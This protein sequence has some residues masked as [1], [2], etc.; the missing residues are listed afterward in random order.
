MLTKCNQSFPFGQNFPK[1]IGHG[2]SSRVSCFK[3]QQDPAF[4]DQSSNGL[5]LG[6]TVEMFLISLC[7]PLKEHL[8]V[9]LNTRDLAVLKKEIQS[10][11]S[12]VCENEIPDTI[13]MTCSIESIVP[14][15]I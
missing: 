12:V 14:R 3:E 10:K 11:Q 9:G 2:N 8:K 15:D 4:F 6:H 5:S 7:E 1:H 13:A